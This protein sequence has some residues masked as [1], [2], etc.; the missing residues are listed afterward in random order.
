MRRTHNP[1]TRRM[2]PV[3][4][5]QRGG[6]AGKGESA[7]G[8]AG[9][10]LDVFGLFDVARTALGGGPAGRS[11][12]TTGLGSIVVEAGVVKSPGLVMTCTGTVTGWNLFSV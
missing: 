8:A 11:S 2:C 6:G 9:G 4:G 7:A 5:D 1:G 3:A 10:F 12:A